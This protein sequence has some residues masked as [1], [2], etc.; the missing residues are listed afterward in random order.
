MA[1]LR[2]VDMVNQVARELG[3]DG[4]VFTNEE[5]REAIE[6]KWP[7]TN[8]T[9]INCTLLL[10]SVNV[11]SRVNYP[12]NKKSRVKRHPDYD[13]LYRVGRAQYVLYQPE[14][15]G[16]WGILKVNDKFVVKQ[17]KAPK[18]EVVEE[19][20]IEELTPAE[21]VEMLQ[22]DVRNLQQELGA[23]IAEGGNPASDQVRDLRREIE[24]KR[25]HLDIKEGRRNTTLTGVEA[26][27]LKEMADAYI[28]KL[29]EQMIFSE[30]PKER[31]GDIRELQEEEERAW[32]LAKRLWV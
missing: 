1:E 20:E 2:A 21:E 29:R 11:Q 28:E 7:G 13:T 10:C 30:D 25:I 26:A 32:A 14:L 23:F 12:E 27:L 5:V 4:R 3:K 24:W 17:V 8:A 9:T 19:F 6:K 31:T 15:H 16:S 18:T 22:R